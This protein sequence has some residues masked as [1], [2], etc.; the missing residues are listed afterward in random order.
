[1]TFLTCFWL[2]FNTTLTFFEQNIRRGF[3][4]KFLIF[5]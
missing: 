4:C 5:N 3:A 1:M 2:F